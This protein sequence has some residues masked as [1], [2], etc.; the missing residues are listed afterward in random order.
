MAT[1][2]L[3]AARAAL[4][5]K[6]AKLLAQLARESSGNLAEEREERRRFEFPEPADLRGIPAI[7]RGVGGAIPGT[8]PDVRDCAAT[9]MVTGQ[10]RGGSSRP[11]LKHRWPDRAALIEALRQRDGDGCYLCRRTLA[12]SEMTIDHIISE[13]LG[14]SH[15][16]ENIAIACSDCNARK[17][18]NIVCFDVSSGRAA[19]V[20]PRVQASRHDL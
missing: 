15:D 3:A 8:R 11:T 9:E 17:G 18:T 5:A 20:Y 6:N 14:G 13:H 19:F 1:F 2:T 7:G 4:A 16:I 12:L 10:H